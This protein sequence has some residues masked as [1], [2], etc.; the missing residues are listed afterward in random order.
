MKRLN[1]SVFSTAS[2]KGKIVHSEPELLPS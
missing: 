1:Y 2:H